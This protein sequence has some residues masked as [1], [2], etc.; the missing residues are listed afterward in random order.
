[1][2]VHIGGRALRLD[3]HR[4][5][6]VMELAI[7]NRDLASFGQSGAESAA[8]LMERLN[9]D[10]DVAKRARAEGLPVPS[11]RYAFLYAGYF[12]FL[13]VRAAGDKVSFLDV[14][15]ML[16]ASARIEEEPTDKLPKPGDRKPGKDPARKAGQRGRGRTRRTT[17]TVKSSTA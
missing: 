3:P 14:M 16:D 7:V 9:E 1:M 17:S 11:S 8:E 2:K 10:R 6:T 15:D 12:A 5:P 4:E 13:A